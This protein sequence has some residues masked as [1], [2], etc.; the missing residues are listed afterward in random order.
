MGRT[1]T[2]RTP[3]LLYFFLPSWPFTI[4]ASGPSS[5]LPIPESILVTPCWSLASAPH[6]YVVSRR[7]WNRNRGTKAPA[8]ARPWER[9]FGQGM[10]RQ[11]RGKDPWSKSMHWHFDGALQQIW[12][13]R[14]PCLPSCRHP[15]ASSLK[16][17][18]QHPQKPT[19]RR[20]L[21]ISAASET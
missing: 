7:S 2:G 15:R 12:E 3:S 9:C 8:R 13:F 17:K 4:P 10:L 1:S 14:I 6:S 20:G 11:P 5:S 21:Y 18:K 16:G 19:G